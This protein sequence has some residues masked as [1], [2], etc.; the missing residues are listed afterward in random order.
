M[1][2]HEEQRRRSLSVWIRTGHGLRR[3]GWP[4][5]EVK[6]N[7]W[8]DPEDG[9]FTFSGAGQYYGAGRASESVPRKQ[10]QERSD[11]KLHYGED[12][13]LPSLSTKEDVEAWRAAELA[14]NGHK[15]GYKEAIEERY[16]FYL[17]VLAGKKHPE[18]EAVHSSSRHS[19]LTNR[20]NRQHRSVASRSDR[21]HDGGAL[22]GERA[23]GGSRGT[24]EHQT[25][26]RFSAGGGSFG[27][28]GAS[29]SW[30]HQTATEF[31]GGGGDFGGG[32]VTGSWDMTERP[33]ASASIRS[34]QAS[35]QGDAGALVSALERRAVGGGKE[36]S[37]VIVRNGYTYEMDAR[38]RTRRVSGVLASTDKAIRSATNQ[39]KAG[40]E[41]RRTSD[42]GGHYIAARFRGPREAFNHFA[43]DANFNRG[44]YRVL[45]DQ[46]AKL[47][48]AGRVV[49][50]TIVPHYRGTSVRPFEID[51][52]FTIN[53]R[54]ES[55]KMP[56][57][58]TEK[59][60]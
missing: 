4:Q 38:G 45:E 9:R 41:D 55:V 58:R 29:G 23:S 56:N 43:Q 12:R 48:R 51:V 17:D 35:R 32:G 49:T 30:A 3:A 20:I 18:A 22:G 14:K 31:S 54:K 7:P 39:R 59:V 28:G 16:R 44:R 11:G 34:A 26:S 13:S 19:G 33:N 15:P 60:P 52:S 57:E 10:T 8:H 37:Y 25:E 46:W 24:I 40:G 6:F 53:G 1:N 42:D 50:V 36:P 2:F 21:T 27:G 47:K 5:V